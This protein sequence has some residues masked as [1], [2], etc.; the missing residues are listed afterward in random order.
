SATDPSSNEEKDEL[1]EFVQQ[2]HQRTERIKKRYSY[3]ED[4]DPTFGFARRPSVRGIR[5]KF[6]STNEIIQ[7]MTKSAL[8]G[9]KVIMTTGPP[10]TAGGNFI[11]DKQSF[12]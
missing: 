3:T 12:A 5:P 9:Q 7:Q 10:P 1:E 6:G 2:E 11:I 8:P 4:D